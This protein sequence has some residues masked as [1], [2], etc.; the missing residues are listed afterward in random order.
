MCFATLRNRA[1]ESVHRHW[2]KSPILRLFGFPVSLF[3]TSHFFCSHLLACSCSLKTTRLYIVSSALL[4][5][6]NTPCSSRLMMTYSFFLLLFCWLSLSAPSSLFPLSSLRRIR[7]S[8][9]SI[10]APFIFKKLVFH[11]YSLHLQSGVLWQ[12][13]DWT[14]VTDITP[15]LNSVRTIPVGIWK[16][17]FTAWKR[18]E[19]NAI[20]Y[21]NAVLFWVYYLFRV[22][23]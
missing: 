10:V 12:V 14:A 18:A 23:F 1:F 22:L 16:I 17:W 11:C 4:Q 7:N 9:L 19:R 8:P 6:E 5:K 21:N 3:D 13:L 15:P 2:N 20:V